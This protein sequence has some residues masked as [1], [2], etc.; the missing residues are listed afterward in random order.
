MQYSSARR[1]A[2]LASAGTLALLAAILFVY[3][4]PSTLFPHA[5]GPAALDA[6][7]LLIWFLIYAAV[8]FPF[9]VWAGYWAP[10]RHGGV[11]ELFPVYLGRLTRGLAAQGLI[12]TASGVALLAAGRQWGAWG[13]FGVLAAL[14]GGLL[15]IRT[16]LGHYLGAEKAEPAGWGSGA[17]AAGWNLA[18]FALS[19]ALPWC[20]VTTVY[21]LVETL[22]GCTLWSLVGLAVLPRIDRRAAG[23][24]LYLSWASFGLLS[25]ATASKAGLP[26][27]WAA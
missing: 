12:M 13:A 2:G 25:R 6:F 10:C 18:G 15:G 14:T 1:L 26:E 4:M 27:E 23:L 20:G 3:Q 9:D 21:G 17:L 24:A 7:A 16:R 22:L 11:C 8:S 5:G 19:A